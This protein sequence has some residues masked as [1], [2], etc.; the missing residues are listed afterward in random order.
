M[1]FLDS[2]VQ[3]ELSQGKLDYDPAKK[4]AIISNDFNHEGEL[5]FTPYQ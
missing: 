4:E 2:F 3:A 1:S 5:N